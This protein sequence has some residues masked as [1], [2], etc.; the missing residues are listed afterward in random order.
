M[1]T[2]ETEVLNMIGE[3]TSSPDVFTDDATGMAQIRDS[4]NDAIEEISMVSGN[5]K[6]TVM[7]PLEANMNFYQLSLNRDQ[8]AWVTDVWLLTLKRRLEQKDF[9]WL[10]HFNPRW[11]Q[12]TG[13]P[14]RYCPIGKD[15]ICVHPAPSA[16][17]DLLEIT[18]VVVPDRYTLDTD[19]VKLRD[20]F[21]WAA[22]NYAVSEYWAS[23]GDAKSAVRHHT[24]YISLL[25]IQ[26]LYPETQERKWY[27]KTEKQNEPIRQ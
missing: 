24:A 10:T 23:R 16:S 22:V 27:Q 18:M 17:T 26:E 9:V 5:H 11:L 14:E 1:N 7:I 21:K 19:R 13:N 4:L 2:L 20:S 15:V 12:N 8:F 3:S 25:G 6:R